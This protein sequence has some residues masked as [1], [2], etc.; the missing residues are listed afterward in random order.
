M[1]SNKLHTSAKEMQI[2]SDDL[3]YS[4]LEKHIKAAESVSASIGS[5]MSIYD[6]SR[7]EHVWESPNHNEWYKDENREYKKIQIHPDDFDKVLKSGIAALKFVYKNN[8]RCRDIKLIRE[9]RAF[10]FGSYRRIIE[11]FIVLETD[12]NNNAWLTLSI[13]DISPDQSAPFTV[14][15]KLVDVKRGEI[16]QT[17]DYTKEKNSIL[18][19]RE[20][21]ILRWIEQGKL[22]KEIAEELHIS[23]ATVNNHRQHILEKL[24]VDNSMEAVRY[25][26]MMGL[27]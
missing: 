10:V 2:D 19:K 16:Y 8:A 9:Y 13:V 4:L 6:N 17:H 26:Q 22:S 12:K 21:E 15:A 3:D 11:Q 23:V 18:S 25:A 5:C 27:L 24:K 7:M 20:L 1:E 14:N